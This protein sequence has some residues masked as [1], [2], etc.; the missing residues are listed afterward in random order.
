MKEIQSLLEATKKDPLKIICMFS[1]VAAKF[2]N[3]GQCDYA[4]VNEILNKL[5]NN[6]AL[7]RVKSCLVKS[8]TW[9][10]WNGLIGFKILFQRAGNSSN[11]S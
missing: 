3:A 8:I 4:M 11:I 9:G 1:S 5:V 10:T 6:E 7:Q 2:D